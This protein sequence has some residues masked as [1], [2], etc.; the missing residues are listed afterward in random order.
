M[1]KWRLQMKT[2]VICGTAVV[3][4]SVSF[5]V[6]SLVYSTTLSSRRD[7]GLVCSFCQP[8]LHILVYGVQNA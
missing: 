7:L 6:S 2:T 1:C 8:E 4:L 3:G 5:L